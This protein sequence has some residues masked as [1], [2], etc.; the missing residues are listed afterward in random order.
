MGWIDAKEL[1]DEKS[2][3]W[4][5]DIDRLA[6]VR[7]II[8]YAGT[9][10]RSVPWHGEGRRVGY[11]V[12]RRDADSEAPGVFMRRLFFLKD[13]DRDSDP[14]TY[15]RTTPT[16]GVDPRT[17]APGVPGRL[18]DRAWPGAQMGARSR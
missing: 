14:E 13:H 16:E 9:R 4:D 6:Y 15:A 7:E 1:Q 18:T 8:T 17:V 11:A 5:E 2:I 12:L 10:R 3:V